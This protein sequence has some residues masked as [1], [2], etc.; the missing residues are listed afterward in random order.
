MTTIQ[1]GQ[2]GLT[3]PTDLNARV[4]EKNE[5]V[6]F[7]LFRES[8]RAG[9][10]MVEGRTFINCRLDGPAVMAAVAGC[11][12]DSTDFGYASGDIRTMVIRSAAPGRMIGALPF[13]DCK[14]IGCMFFAVG[15]TGPE[16]FL[17]Q[18]LALET[19]A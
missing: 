10:A 12:F 16:T 7:D 14:F 15:F 19:R 3:R 17:H 4:F 18:I 2:T 5:V 1:Q 6:L 9:S 11:E 8:L 13:K